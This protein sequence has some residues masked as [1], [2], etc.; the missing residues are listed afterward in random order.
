MDRGDGGR[1]GALVGVDLLL[2]LVDVDRLANGPV[3]KD[4]AARDG[5]RVALGPDCGL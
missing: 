4:L 5:N 2:E 3:E 1:E